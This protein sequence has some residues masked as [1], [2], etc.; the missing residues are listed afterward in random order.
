MIIALVGLC[1]F[2]AWLFAA[3][4]WQPTTAD[5]YT[6]D[7]NVSVFANSLVWISLSY[8]GF[9]AAV[10]VAGEAKDA[11][12]AIPRAMIFGTILT[13]ILYVALNAVFLYAPEPSAVAGQPEIASIAAEAL[14]GSQLRVTIEFI[15]C[16]SLLSSITAMLLAGPR[17]YAKMSQDGVFPRIFAADSGGIPRTSILL[18]MSLGCLLVLITDLQ[19][20]LSYL[21][22]TLS[23]SLALAVSTLFIRHIRFGECP[24]SI[25]YPI[26]PIIFI[27]ATVLFSGLSAIRE[28]VQLIAAAGTVLLGFGW[29]ISRKT[30]FISRQKQM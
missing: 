8:S 15:I 11:V 12:N 16:L 14:G 24:N 30:N 23:L 5:S 28:P 2:A 22:F 26:A 21:G 18:Q 13:I 6:A 27:S 1:I 4:S 3:G 7:F 9:N 17:V 19:G 25:F 10:Y 29:Y 20:L